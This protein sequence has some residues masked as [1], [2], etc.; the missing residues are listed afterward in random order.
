MKGEL[1]RCTTFADDVVLTDKNI[2]VLG[3]ELRT[4][5][6]RNEENWIENRVKCKF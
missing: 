4:S 2:N 6:R 5:E 1:P 3:G